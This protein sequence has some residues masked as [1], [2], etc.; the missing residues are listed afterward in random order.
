MADVVD[1]SA[2]A[3]DYTVHSSNTQD[4]DVAGRF[5]DS[6]KP[7]READRLRLAQWLLGFLG[8]LTVGIF[9]AY[10]KHPKNDALRAIFEL[11]K[12]GVLPLIT[13][14]VSFYFSRTD[15]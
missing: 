3:S 9:I 10:A 12:I 8:L 6:V 13:L 7:I 14:I 15:Q 1:I 5:S 11:F 2:Y 4:V